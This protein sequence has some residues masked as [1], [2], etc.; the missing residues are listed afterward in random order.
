[1]LMKSL[2]TVVCTIVLVCPVLA[3]GGITYNN[4]AHDGVGLTFVHGPSP[5]V[6]ALHVF[7]L[8]SLQTPIPFADRPTIPLMTGGWPGV[9]VLDYDRDGDLDIYVTNSAGFANGLFQNQLSQ[10]GAATFVNVAAAAGVAATNHNSS[11]VCFGDIDNDGDH[12]LIVLGR[13]DPNILFENLGNGSF[14]EVVGS[15]IEGGTRWSVSGSLGDV[16]GDGLL[17]LIVANFA[18]AGASLWN[19]VEPFALNEHNQ[20]FLNNGNNTAATS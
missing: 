6:P 8:E 19:A 12:D 16:N 18:D 20:L 3:D 5:D 9:A 2:M 1:M 13:N 7:Q 15:G 4:I 14:A 11:G 10:S 17:D